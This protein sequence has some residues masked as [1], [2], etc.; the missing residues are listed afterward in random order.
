[1]TPT[2]GTI[3]FA[4]AWL[5]TVAALNSRPRKTLGWKTPAEAFNEVLLSAALTESHPP[6][7]T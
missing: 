1:M 7:L 6:V 4:A 2:L 3:T 5:A